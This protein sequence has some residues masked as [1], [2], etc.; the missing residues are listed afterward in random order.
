MKRTVLA[1][2]LALI[3]AAAFAQ[4]SSTQQQQFSRA[5]N[6]ALTTITPTP[7]GG[8]TI[9]SPNGSTQSVNP[10]PGGGYTVTTPNGTIFTNRMPTGAINE[11]R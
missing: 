7:G 6:G 5:P 8:F 11:P 10:A 1:C 4:Q 3:P 9:R 2:S